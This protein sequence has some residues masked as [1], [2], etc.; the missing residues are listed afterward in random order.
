MYKAVPVAAVAVLVAM[1]GCSGVPG[2]TAG[3]PATI[4]S[5]AES[6]TSTPLAGSSGPVNTPPD[7]TYPP[8][9]S[10]TGVN[11]G[12]VVDRTL[13]LLRDEPVVVVGLERFR[14][15]AYADYRYAA[16]ATHA[17]LQLMIHNGYSDISE[18]DIYTDPIAEY[19]RL[20]RNDRTSFD[21]SNT[22]VRETRY[23][24][25]TTVLAVLSRVIT[26]GNF[27]ANDTYLVDG[28]RRIQYNLTGTVYE[29][30]TDEQGHLIVGENGV[31]R[32]AK[33]T[34]TRAG[35]PK[36]FQYAVLRRSD[37]HVASP[38]WLAAAGDGQGDEI[39]DR[40]ESAPTK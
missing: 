36:R 13:T 19:R 8:G 30:A 9:F 10:A 7:V 35:E 25:S 33:M 14:P 3:G 34:Y 23:G 5:P 20:D 31:V 17:R 39:T 22:S 26:F 32:E 16:N 28:E 12:V 29:N 37:V 1:S 6:G 21:T 40:A 27:R 15:G 18:W 2:D 24:V 38:P 4:T 11:N